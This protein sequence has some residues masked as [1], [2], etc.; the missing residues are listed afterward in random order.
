MKVS[1]FDFNLPEDR[2][3]L[4]P[5]RPRDAARM[6]VISEDELLD[7]GVADLPGLLC[8]GDVMVFN[9][10]RV[11]P[12]RLY[13]I[14][15]A[16]GTRGEARIE[17]LLHKRVDEQ[18][19]Q[20]FARPGKRLRPGD[21]IH[22]GDL[23][24]TV[25]M[26]GDGGELLVRFDRSGRDLDLAILETGEMPLPPYIAGKRA[27]DEGDLADYQTMFAARDGAV[28]AP[29]ASLHF[30]EGLMGRLAEAGIG[31]V[32]LTLHVG[33]GTFLPVKAEDTR[34]HRMHAEWGEIT[35]ETARHLNDVR[36]NGG[37][38]VAVGTTSLRLL[39]SAADESGTI[40]PFADETDIFITPGYRFRAVDVL[41]TNF[42]LPRSTLFML[43][44]AFAGLEVMKGA[45]RHA[46]D[47]GYRFY[48]YGDASLIFPAQE[49]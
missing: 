37:R 2:I 33:A 21:D 13:G 3:A 22:M 49:R 12:A 30:T 41:M 42:H 35:P 44:S 23:V 39:E 14:R 11:I 25:M 9:D 1:D 45:Y 28:A 10:T 15:R 46:I 18:E 40:Q 26:K 27:T 29:T 36:R 16:D 6:L 32:T 34:D 17:L 8:A 31:H 47:A 7:A 20:A 48:S 24:G 19:W 4:R 38:I 5:A 43:V